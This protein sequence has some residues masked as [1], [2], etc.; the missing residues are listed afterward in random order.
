MEI[1]E[2]G[3]MRTR[4][5]GAVA[6]LT[7]SVAAALAGCHSD[8]PAKG[9]AAGQSAGPLPDPCTL[10]TPAQLQQAFTEPLH[11]ADA[12]QPTDGYQRCTYET[13]TVGREVFVD[14]YPSARAYDAFKKT[15]Q[16]SNPVDVSGVGQAAFR[17]TP[18][19]HTAIYIKMKGYALSLVAFGFTQGDPTDKALDQLG[20][21][22]VATAGG[23]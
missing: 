23:A 9:S 20:R 11:R 13:A 4:S 19:G 17:T 2:S 18:S 1:A 10:L 3:R 21:E 22:A 8:A 7:L 5:A 14:V 6:A 12:Q 16:D 15:A